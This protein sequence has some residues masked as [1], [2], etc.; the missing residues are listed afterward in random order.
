MQKMDEV[1]EILKTDAES[2][3]SSYGNIVSKSI[4]KDAIIG[5]VFSLIVAVCL[6]FFKDSVSPIVKLEIG[7]FTELV[8][9]Y[10]IICL[11]LF[12]GILVLMKIKPGFWLFS[13]EKKSLK[14]YF[15]IGYAFNLINFFV[16]ALLVVYLIL[17]LIVT[18]T[19]VIGNSMYDTFNEGDK[20]FVWHALYNPSRNDIVVI[21]ASRYSYDDSENFYIKR[22][23]GMPG[24]R[25]M[26]TEKGI[27]IND[28]EFDFQNRFDFMEGHLSLLSK[29]ED[30]YYIIPEGKYL[31]LG[32]NRGHSSDS[33]T[34]GLIDK[35]QILGRAVFRIWP[36]NRMGLTMS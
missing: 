4:V 1:A 34:F 16:S 27:S 24:D 20:I 23:V 17:L 26:M 8:I 7:M 11:V 32:D 28:V 3:L 15:N 21:D 18:P 19:T 33:R 2:D 12:V 35:E 22:L 6:I 10:L 14:Y 9:V 25:I 31:L 29:D 13:T 30:G 36:I 5:F